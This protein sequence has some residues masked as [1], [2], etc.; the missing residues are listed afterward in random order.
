MMIIIKILSIIIT[1]SSTCT[2]AKDIDRRYHYVG[3]NPLTPLDA[4][5]YCINTFGTSLATVTTE[6]EN[7]YITETCKKVDGCDAEGTTPKNCGCIIGLHDVSN[8]QDSSKEEWTW[9]SRFPYDFAKDFTNWAQNE[10]SGA[11]GNH[12]CVSVY[13]GCEAAGGI[14]CSDGLWADKV[15]AGTGS[16]IQNFFCNTVQQ[17]SGGERICQGS[18]HI[19]KGLAYDCSID[20]EPCWSKEDVPETCQDLGDG[21]NRCYWSD[22][23][24]IYWGDDEGQNRICGYDVDYECLELDGTLTWITDGFGGAQ[25]DPTVGYMS[26]LRCCPNQATGLNLCTET[27]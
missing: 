21:I 22:K 18:D 2:L 25:A 10:P 1:F 9:W 12:D 26:C 7:N 19:T 3:D 13:K 17:I 15:R 6:N 24:I 23:N 14:S 5:I 20:A 16:I 11:T 4:N 8:E 27:I